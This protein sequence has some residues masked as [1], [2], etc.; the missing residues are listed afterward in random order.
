MTPLTT[1]GWVWLFATIALSILLVTDL[2]EFS[3]VRHLYTVKR[4]VARDRATLTS[5]T[6][7]LAVMITWMLHLVAPW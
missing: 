3:A 1:S 2:V 7:V 6:V 4:N 5:E